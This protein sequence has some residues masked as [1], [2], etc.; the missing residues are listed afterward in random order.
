VWLSKIGGSPSALVTLYCVPH[1]GVGA[2]AYRGWDKALGP[3]IEVVSIQLPGR[4]NRHRE[5]ALSSMSQLIPV[6]TS[7]VLD[8]AKK[9]FA[10]FG[11]SMGALIAFET[12]HE[13]EKR[14][15]KVPLHFF[16]SACAAPQLSARPSPIH[17]LP[18]ADF[19]AELMKRYDGIPRAILE[20]PEFMQ[21]VLPTV[22]ADLKLYEE[23]RYSSKAP[24]R[25][26]I[27]VFGGRNDST[28]SPDRLAGWEQQTLGAF[29][30]RLLDSGHLYLQTQ[31]AALTRDIRDALLAVAKLS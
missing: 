25:C 26:P 4:E 2:S 31:L 22:R 1:A 16:V 14:S 18:D 28:I 24:L 20:D 5:P 29:N 8:R 27:S 6:L 12:V 9:P 23:Y 7:A 17:Q 30:L 19:V 3:D 21:A 11:N 13:I 15:G 10:I